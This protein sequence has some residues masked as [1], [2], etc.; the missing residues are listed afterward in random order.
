MYRKA[1]NILSNK[2][3]G[4]LVKTIGVDFVSKVIGF[5]VLPAYLFLMSAEE[6]G[7]FNLFLNIINTSALI[8][9]FNIYVGFIKNYASVESPVDKGKALYTYGVIYLFL[10]SLIYIFLVCGLY[11]RLIIGLLGNSAD[12]F[13]ENRALIYS[14]IISNVFST[15]LYSYLM[16]QKNLLNFRRYVFLKSVAISI[17]GLSVLYIC[18]DLEADYL[19]LLIILIVDIIFSCI[20]F[21]KIMVEVVR[22]FNYAYLRE[23]LKI[24]FPIT[25][26]SVTYFAFSTLDITLLD[27]Y[28]TAEELRDYSLVL[29]FVSVVPMLMASFQSVFTPNFFREKSI[30]ANYIRINYV[31]KQLIIGLMVLCPLVFCGIHISFKIGLFPDHYSAIKTIVIPLIIGASAHALTHL[32]KLLYTQLVLNQISFMLNLVTAFL[33]V[34][35]YPYLIG[36]YGMIGAAMSNCLVGLFVFFSHVTVMSFIIKF[37]YEDHAT[38]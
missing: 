4:N 9:G 5:L 16:S 35:L 38:C 21:S 20:F 27:K 29:T 30:N 15:F 3:R 11:D 23:G 10:L 37:K 8:F 7:R 24:G 32:Y 6:F 34:G 26:S 17:C 25:L 28:G 1:L 13:V 12:F 22:G 18:Q 14:L 33:A 19:R 31:V 2:L 36:K